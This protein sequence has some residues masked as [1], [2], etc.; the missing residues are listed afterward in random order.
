MAATIMLLEAPAHFLH[1]LFL[2]YFHGGRGQ[3]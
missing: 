2:L 1:S 3:Q